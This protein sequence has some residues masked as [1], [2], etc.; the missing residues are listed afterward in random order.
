MCLKV[1]YKV[2]KAYFH[3]TWSYRDNS[4]HFP[5]ISLL[6]LG[7][8][9]MPL[10]CLMLNWAW[11]SWSCKTVMLEHN[12]PTVL[13]KLKT[14]WTSSFEFIREPYTGSV[15]ILREKIKKKRLST[16]C[17]V[18]EQNNG[19][20]GTTFLHC[21]KIMKQLSMDMKTVELKKRCVYI[22]ARK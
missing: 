9:L 11:R 12:L 19:A 14:V 18:N 15:A 17:Y 6:H 8:H 7:T 3:I 20:V 13:R 2:V 1:Y 10:T 4:P 5:T 16:I 21:S 22:C